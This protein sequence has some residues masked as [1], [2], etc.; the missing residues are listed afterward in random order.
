M[1]I[2]TSLMSLLKFTLWEHWRMTWDIII[3]ITNK[4]ADLDFSWSVQ[5]VAKSLTGKVGEEKSK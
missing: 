3:L 1:N 2:L 4:Y 5:M